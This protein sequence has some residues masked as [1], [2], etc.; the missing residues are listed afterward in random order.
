M[1]LNKFSRKS[2]EKA[3]GEIKMQ[4]TTDTEDA[5]TRNNSKTKVKSFSIRL[6]LLDKVDTYRTTHR[7]DSG[8]IPSASQIVNDA[9]EAYLR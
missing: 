6:D 7:T 1:A 4:K 8:T 5:G 9:L 2:A 3:P